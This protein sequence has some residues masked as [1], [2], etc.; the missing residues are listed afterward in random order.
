[1]NKKENTDPIIVIIATSFARTKLLLERS[2]KSVYEQININPHQIYIVD[3]NSVKKGKRYSDEHKNIHD[4]IKKLRKDILKPK[5]DKFKKKRETYNIKFENFFHTNLIQNTRTKGFSGTGAW[6]SGAF[7]ALR[8]SGRNY[9]LAFLD[10]DD[11]W[12]INYLETLFK[13]VAKPEKKEINGKLR[14]IKTIASIAGFLRIEKKK[15]IE[16]KAKRESF[17]K[18]SFFVRNPGLQGSNLFI[19]LKTFWTIGGFDESLKSVTDRDLGIRLAEYIR[20]RRLK[21][22]TFIDDILM[23]HYAIS[24]NRVTTNL[25]N[26]KQGLDL[27]YRKYYHQFSKELQEKS[28]KRAKDLFNYEISNMIPNI[29]DSYSLKNEKKDIIKPFNLVIGTISNNAN[30]LIELFRSFFSLHKKYGK[31]LSD[32]RFLVLENTSNEYEIRPIINYFVTKKNLNIELI[33]NT[34]NGLSIAENRTYLQKKVYEKGNKEF[35]NN[36]IS[37]IIDDDHLFKFDTENE[38]QTPN[39][40]KIISEQKK[41]KVD[42][43]FGQISDAPPLPFLNTLRTQLIDFYYNLTYFANCNPK[44]KF[45]LNDLQKFNIERKEFYYDLSS[46]HYQ[47]LEYPYYQHSKELTN[48]KAFQNFLK[49]TALLLNGVNIFRKLTFNFETIGKITNK[50]SIYRG[51]NTVVYNSRLLLTPNYTPEREYNRRSDFNWSI[52][53]K[54]IFNYKLYEI[55]LPLKHDRN[56]QITPLITNEKKLEADIK[57]LIFYRLFENIISKENWEGKIEHKNELRYYEQIKSQI[58][59]KIKINNYRTQNLIYLILEILKDAKLWWFENEYC[60]EI[61]YHVQ[62]NIFTLEVLKI[63]LGKRKFQSLIKDLE[64]KMKIDNNFINKVIA[65]IKGIRGDNNVYDLWR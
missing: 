16:I 60:A 40:F 51:G 36:Q 32:Y 8:Y 15:T 30:N 7:E 31:W 37:W 41:H 18:E 56:L 43:V 44:D 65:E 14:N 50:S 24:E 34:K 26:K 45:E 25:D 58:F 29:R 35:N 38:I 46:K 6:N 64:G 33:K 9:F 47:H 39:Y 5:F 62:Q 1:M 59:R 54:N 27:F 20:I 3:D 17:N 2:L 48:E 23:N 57:G 63:E 53:N 55:I 28:L 12:K 22:V 10:D 61:N 11:E 19:E 52:I 4:V 13:S 49:E 42:A 21:K